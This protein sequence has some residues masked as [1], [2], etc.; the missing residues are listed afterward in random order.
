MLTHV[1]RFITLN[2]SLRRLEFS[3]SLLGVYSAWNSRNPCLAFTRR[4]I[5][6]WSCSMMLFKYCTGR[7]RQRRRSGPSFL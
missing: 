5:A 6:R 1:H 7:C 2:G 4:L 3:E